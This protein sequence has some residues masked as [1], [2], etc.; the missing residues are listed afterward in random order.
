MKNL[1]ELILEIVDELNKNDI[2]AGRTIIHKI[3][4]LIFDNN[5]RDFYF[6]PYYYGPYSK[7][8]Q[9]TIQSLYYKNFLVFEENKAGYKL[10]KKNLSNH[11]YKE[12]IKKT[13]NFLKNKNLT[14][15]KLIAEFV[16]IFYF[17]NKNSNKNNEEII[18]IIKNVS[19]FIWPEIYRKKN[20]EILKYI[21]LSKE[22]QDSLNI[23]DEVT[24]S[25]CNY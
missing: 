14:T 13:V 4:F 16:K 12:K 9:A 8:I 22:F 3:C 6:E 1:K 15:T 17:Y 21:T 25:T 10:K 5:E 19:K 20:E 11:E 23:G 2:F 18:K 7:T 24:E